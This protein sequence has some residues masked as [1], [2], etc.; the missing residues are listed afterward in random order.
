MNDKDQS[1]VVTSGAMNSFIEQALRCIDIAPRRDSD[2]A[3][4]YYVGPAIAYDYLG[5]IGGRHVTKALKMMKKLKREMT[6]PETISEQEDLLAAAREKASDGFEKCITYAT[7]AK[8]RMSPSL[9]SLIPA[10]TW[11]QVGLDNMGRFKVPGSDE[12]INWLT[13][14]IK[15]RK[16]MIH[17]LCN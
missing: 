9:G 14:A 4:L 15:G 1:F 2:L 6:E 16:E 7:K 17:Y 12:A 8:N 13:K 10:L 5:L 3:A 11:I